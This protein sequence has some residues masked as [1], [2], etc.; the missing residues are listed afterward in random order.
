MNIQTLQWKPATGWS[1]PPGTALS[2]NREA[3]VVDGST[4]GE[5]FGASVDD[6]SPSVAPVQLSDTHVRGAMRAIEF[7]SDREICP[8]GVVHGGDLHYQTMT[9][10]V[11]GAVQ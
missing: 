10:P 3:A 8:S 1:R 11:I 2:P 6:G 5:V 9:L 4:T 7:Y